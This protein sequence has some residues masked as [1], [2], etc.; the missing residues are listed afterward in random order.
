MNYLLEVLKI[1]DGA[2]NSDRKKV[3]A[4]AEGDTL[5]TTMDAQRLEQFEHPPEVAAIPGC[6]PGDSRPTSDV[7]VY[8]VTK[9]NP[10]SERD[11][12]THQERGCAP[13]SNPCGDCG[14]SVI[15]DEEDLDLFHQKLPGLG[16][17]GWMTRTGSRRATLT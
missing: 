1:L 3:I 13:R 11:L 6:P 7:V 4:Y 17:S 15:L 8:R 2:V 14:L 10:P 12:K 16:K 5:P 9:K